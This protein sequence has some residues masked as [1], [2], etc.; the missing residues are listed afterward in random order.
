M[1]ERGSRRCFEPTIRGCVPELDEEI[2][3]SLT[4]DSLM[5]D[6]FSR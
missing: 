1:G 2:I 3:F 4:L 5:P 6:A